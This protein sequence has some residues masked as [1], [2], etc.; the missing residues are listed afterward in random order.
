MNCSK[1][2]SGFALARQILAEM[3]NPNGISTSRFRAFSGVFSGTSILYG[4]KPPVFATPRALFAFFL[5][6]FRAGT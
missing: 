2:Y 3:R 5:V 6:F 1:Q 4:L